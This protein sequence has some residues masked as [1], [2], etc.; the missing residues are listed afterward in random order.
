MRHFL[1]FLTACLAPVAVS[2]QSHDPA[3]RMAAQRD[4]MAR[5]SFMDGVWRGPAWSVTP[6]GRRELTQTERIGPFLGGAVRLIEGRGYLADGSVG[7]N[8]FG[9]VAYD[10]A[11]Q[12]YS[13]TSWAMGQ[14]I[15]VPLVLS[16]TGY[17]WEV[18]AG[19][20]ARI[21]YTAEIASGRWHEYGD[22]IVGEAPPMRIFDMQLTRVADTDWPLGEPVPM[23]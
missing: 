15:T 7:F 2:A 10:P 14:N 21:R 5:L 20:G 22:R 6:A 4:A 3:V 9:V 18:P 11:T 12:A 13:I 19:P 16:P 17:V 23:R 8:A 1:L